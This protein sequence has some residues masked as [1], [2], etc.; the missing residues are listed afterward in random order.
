[1]HDPAPGLHPIHRPSTMTLHV[2]CPILFDIRE[3]STPFLLLFLLTSHS[4][5]IASAPEATAYPPH[6]GHTHRQRLRFRM[7]DE[8]RSPPPA[9]IL[10]DTSG[11][12]PNNDAARHRKPSHGT[13]WRRPRMVRS[14]SDAQENKGVPRRQ[15]W[16]G[17]PHG[18]RIIT[19]NDPSCMCVSSGSV[20]PAAT[21]A[22][23]VAAG[24]STANAM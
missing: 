3:K 14:R 21:S 8:A 16:S 5:L 17:M 4:F 22:A 7:T 2:S 12:L 20:A 13:R 23:V 24:S 9:S 18:S 15:S 1:M 19:R 10:R 11:I 6:R